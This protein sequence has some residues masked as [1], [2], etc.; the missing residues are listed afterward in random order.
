MEMK[1]KN[2]DVDSPDFAF[3]GEAAVITQ[4]IDFCFNVSLGLV[5]AFKSYLNT[6]YVTLVINLPYGVK[7]AKGNISS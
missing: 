5:Q 2:Y 3:I 7:Y 4:E 1:F 6:D